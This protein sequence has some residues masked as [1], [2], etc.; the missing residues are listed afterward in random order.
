MEQ[1]KSDHI[2]L[3]L[4]TQTS[5]IEKDPRFDYEPMLSAHPG[6]NLPQVNIGGKMLEAP[7]WISSMTGGTE[8]A[9]TIN[10]NLARLAH[11]FGFGMG[12]DRAMC[13]CAMT[14]ICPISTCA[15]LLAQTG[16]STPTWALPRSKNT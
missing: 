12:W 2:N 5:G 8:G 13:C 4:E 1:R 6:N 14:N 10:H 11:E 16:L 3:A 7:I 15:G 9:R